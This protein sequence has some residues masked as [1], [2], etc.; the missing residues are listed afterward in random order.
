[1]ARFALTSLGAMIDD[2]SLN[3]VLKV[4]HATK[5]SQLLTLLFPLSWISSFKTMICNRPCIVATW[6]C[7]RVNFSSHEQAFVNLCF[8]VP[9]VTSSHYQQGTDPLS[10]YNLVVWVCACVVCVGAHMIIFMLHFHAWSGPCGN[11]LSI[12][13]T[14][15]YLI[16][17]SKLG[18]LFHW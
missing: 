13:R 18:L 12:C 1:M 4:Y 3:T 6:W 5:L 11:G 15:M 7:R 17:E 14:T 2:W 10:W 8:Q 9:V 16:C